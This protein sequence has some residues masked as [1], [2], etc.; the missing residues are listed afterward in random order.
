VE[1]AQAG[2]QPYFGCFMVVFGEITPTIYFP[3]RM[4][5]FYMGGQVRGALAVAD[6]QNDWQGR[7]PRDCI[8]MGLAGAVK[9]A[10]DSTTVVTSSSIANPSNILCAAVHGL[11]TGDS[12]TIAGHITA[13]PD[14]N[15]VHVATVIDT[16]NFTI[17][18]NVTT[19]G[20]GGTVKRDGDAVQFTA[21]KSTDL[22]AWV[23]IY[24]TPPAIADAAKEVDSG[25]RTEPDGTFA[26][27]CFK[28]GD[29]IRLN[30][31]LI[32]AGVLPGAHLAFDLMFSTPMPELDIF[33]VA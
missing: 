19:G 23:D 31:D 5:E 16:L 13:V 18:V 32:G 25:V 11:T 1:S 21:E 4:G 24:T 30:V 20:T 9:T 27:H 14:I 2:T 12:V 6:Y 8:Y 29:Y 3:E 7:V 17:P 10:P 15:G 22:S 26:N 33:K 28:E